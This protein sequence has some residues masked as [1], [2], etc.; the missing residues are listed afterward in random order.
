MTDHGLNQTTAEI[1]LIRKCI[2][3]INGFRSREL[4]FQKLLNKGEPRRALNY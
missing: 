3:E 2:F 1:N 4:I